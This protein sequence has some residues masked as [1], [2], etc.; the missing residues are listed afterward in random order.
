[1]TNDRTILARPRQGSDGG[2]GRWLLRIAVV[3]VALAAGLTA[4]LAGN[5][6]DEGAGRG[7]APEPRIV[8]PAALARAAALSGHPVYW[9]GSLPGTELQLSEAAGGDVQVSY[10]ARGA[11]GAEPGSTLTVGSYPLSHPARALAA[12]AA[13][14]R[15]ELHRGPGG[16][17]VVT[18]SEARGSAYFTGPDGRVQVEVYAP[19][20]GRALRLVL[21]G[22]VRPAR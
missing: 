14:P 8:D 4:W 10:L 21:A 22:R 2:T 16:H 9:L 15:S 7:Q 5:G 12:F 17:E 20:P 1:M 18:S 11:E 6:G 13:R 3:L 19:V